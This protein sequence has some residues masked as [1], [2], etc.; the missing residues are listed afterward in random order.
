MSIVFFHFPGCVAVLDDDDA[1]LESLALAMAGK[2]QMA[3]YSRQQACIDRI[4]D[5]RMAW[6]ELVQQKHGW[7]NH[8]R[9]GRPLLAKILADSLASKPQYG[10]VKVLVVDYAMPGKNGLQV[11]QELPGLSA[12]RILLTGQADTQIAVSAFNSHLIEQYIP[13]QSDNI[14]QRITKSVN[15]MLLNV[16]IKKFDFWQAIFSADQFAV[17]NQL[18]FDNQLHKLLTTRWV[19]YV[20]LS[21][22][23]GVLGFDAQGRAGWLQLE[24][25]SSL[26][27]TAEMAQEQ[28]V[29]TEVV[30]QMLRGEILLA[31][32]LKQALGLHQIELTSHAI[33]M[34]IDPPVYA[35]W[36]DLPES[37]ARNAA[38]G[39]ASFIRT[40][41]L[42]VIG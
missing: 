30:N 29:P 34:D 25:A 28:Q 7:I 21:E 39:Y 5:E 31:L 13:K 3:F 36:F 32:E 26:K 6:Y 15:E 1:Y 2:R 11:L 37:C 33:R 40:H 9:T 42:H 23:F 19:E 14:G 38:D 16:D 17:L 27:E 10:L 24:T 4:Q 20:L 41:N 18:S 22:P 35:A 8:W 12:D